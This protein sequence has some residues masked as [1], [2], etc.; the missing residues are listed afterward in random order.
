M[1]QAK[2]LMSIS[3]FLFSFL[4][5][6]CQS[7]PP[8][9]IPSKEEKKI[10]PGE[11]KKADIK[12][13]AEQ[14]PIY[15][16][17]LQGKTIAL[18][19]NQTSQV[20]DQHLVDTLMALGVKVKHIFAPEHGFRG[21]ADAGAIIKDDE[22]VATGLPVISLY[23]KKKQPGKNE[24]DGIDLVIFDIQDVGV[25]FYTYISSIHYLMEGCAEYGVPL[26]VLDRP[27]PNG[28]YIDGPVLDPKFKSFVGIHPVPVVHGMTVGE[29]AQMINGEGWLTKGRKCE[30]IVIPCA[31]Y[32]HQMSYE[33]PIKPSPNLPNARAVYLYPSLC[34]FE[35]T[36][37]SVGRG[38]QKQFQVLGHPNSTIGNYSFKPVSQAGATKPLHQNKKCRGFDLTGETAEFY[39][40]SGKL[41]LSYLIN[42]YQDY[43][44]DKPFFNANNFIHKLAGTDQLKL[45]IE[46]GWTEA[47][48]SASWQEELE[49]YR[50]IRIK[51]LLYED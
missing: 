21:E 48:I 36:V 17:Q 38:T 30:L 5:W 15:L 28:H 24:L 33:L 7:T 42:F 41:D 47:E 29:F 27:N 32:N 31:N 19:V 51:Y 10:P 16:S 13:G 11:E 39:R 1:N 50:K 34:F 20:G 18:M 9:N 2:I 14:M 26:M 37:V 40:K 12:T 45:Q 35:G 8:A 3:L 46:K 49:A 6:H 23:G 4:F 22:D 25:R 44:G 43:Q